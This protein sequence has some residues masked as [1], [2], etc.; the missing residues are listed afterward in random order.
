MK[1]NSE[2]GIRTATIAVTLIDDHGH[3]LGKKKR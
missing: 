1:N 2:I 3:S